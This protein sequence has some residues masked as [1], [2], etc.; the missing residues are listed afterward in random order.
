MASPID[1]KVGA[2]R[3]QWEEETRRVLN[4]WLKDNP[5]PEV[6]PNVV[7]GRSNFGS[8]ERH[9]SK[10]GKGGKKT[11]GKGPKPLTPLERCSKAMSRVLRHEAG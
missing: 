10:M 2:C 3:L 11:K 5:V 7:G 1:D 6:P 4:D 8:S 9:S